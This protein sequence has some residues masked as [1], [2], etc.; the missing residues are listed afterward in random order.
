[1]TQEQVA[2]FEQ[3]RKLCHLHDGHRDPDFCKSVLGIRYIHNNS[4]SGVQIVKR[5]CAGK[6]W[7]TRVLPGDKRDAQ[8]W[9]LTFSTAEK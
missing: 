2:L 8:N 5:S 1:M 9:H 7:T 6:R 3:G 4:N